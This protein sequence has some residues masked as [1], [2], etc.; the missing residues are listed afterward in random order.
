MKAL[1]LT[2]ALCGSLCGLPYTCH[3][4]LNKKGD[5][6]TV[7]EKHVTRV[8]DKYVLPPEETPAYRYNVV[9]A[10]DNGTTTALSVSETE[11]NRIENGSTI[12]INGFVIQ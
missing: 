6:V 7:Q 4:V 2:I 11:F 8:P 10:Y 5:K 12:T 1:I 3:N 9:V